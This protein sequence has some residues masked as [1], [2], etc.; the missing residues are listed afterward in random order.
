MSHRLLLLSLA[1]LL[2]NGSPLLAQRAAP[3]KRMALIAQAYDNRRHDLARSGVF[4]FTN[5][6]RDM[7]KELIRH[8]WDARLW[9]SSPEP[10]LPPPAE[11]APT[12]ANLRRFL[13]GL[14][15][16]RADDEVVVVLVGQL[17]SLEAGGPDKGGARLYFCP[18]D[19][20]YQKL[21]RAAEVKAK[22]RLLALED[23]YDS[24][25]G[26]P[27]RRKLLVLVTAPSDTYWPEK[28]ALPLC[29]RLPK[30]PGP[31]AGLAVLTSC[32]EGEFTGA[33]AA[34]LNA[35]REGLAGLNADGAPDGKDRDGAV[36]AEELV[37]Y[38][39]RAVEKKA[40]GFGK[41]S[42]PQH[43]TV[44]GRLP[45]DWVLA[46]KAVASR[47]K[48]LT[49]PFPAKQ[50]QARQ[51][52]VAKLLKLEGPVVANGLGMKLA[53]IPPGEFRLG[54]DGGYDDERPRPRIRLPRPFFLGQHEVTQAQYQRLMG[55]NP[56]FFRTV[57][58]Q[59]TAAFP[60]EQVTFKQ[61]VLFCNALSER[62]KLPPYYRLFGPRKDKGGRVVDF[63]D[64]APAGGPGYR[65]PTEAEWEWACRAGTES[66]FAFGETLSGKQA[67]VDA[68]RPGGVKEG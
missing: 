37:A 63:A 32:A 51:A 7:A 30:L 57:P 26:C 35:L 60:V 34:F 46:G 67:N 25:K 15:A 66:P 59:D 20:Q 39:Q 36:T 2:G 41:W 3:P 38:A 55:D 50:A 6:S 61:A 62:E 14:A 11:E 58:G 31:P 22:H 47:W 44:L 28:Y 40:S 29:A 42:F 49:V 45:R 23:V 10:R 24:L 21:A 33:V 54:S 18:E 56:S 43:P 27:A 19:A 12:E 8:G 68:G 17:V 1:S 65:L 52:E 53:V 13:K 48:L 64:Y 16:L 9:A 5:G 4:M